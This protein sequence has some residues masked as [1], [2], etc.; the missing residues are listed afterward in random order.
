VAV[1]SEALCLSNCTSASDCSSTCCVP[2]ESGGQVCADSSYCETSCVAAG[3]EC[4][5]GDC[6]PGSVCVWIDYVGAICQ[7][8]SAECPPGCTNPYGSSC[9]RP[10]FCGGDCVGSPCCD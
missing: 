2:L 8:Q 7:A 1:E 4:S 3:D 9:C 5:P 6:C 10:P